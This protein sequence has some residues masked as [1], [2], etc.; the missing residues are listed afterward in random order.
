[1]AIDYSGSAQ[2]HLADFTIDDTSPMWAAISCWFNTDI[3]TADQ[4]LVAIG[5]T[6]EGSR[7]YLRL[8]LISANMLV[9]ETFSLGIQY[10]T[11]TTTGY[12]TGTWH[13]AFGCWQNGIYSV[14]QQQIWIDGGSS[15]FHSGRV[16]TIVSPKLGLGVLPLALSKVLLFNGR[17]AEVAVWIKNNAAD[18][19]SEP[20]V[21]E[22][23]A[24]AKGFSPLTVKPQN[25]TFYAPLVRAVQDVRG[26]RTLTAT[27][28]PTV[29]DHCR[30]IY[31][32]KRIAVPFV[33]A[34]TNRV[35]SL[36]GYYKSASRA[37]LI[38]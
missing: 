16:P 23:V 17:L 2:Y 4:T 9:A 3:S 7:N 30:V 18:D 31:P 15:S 20:T 29:A 22:I 28:S 19:G 5:D 10:A 38:G 21:P 11:G 24:L 27:G 35:V 14:W 12:S 26:G 13:H 37:V 34:A 36:G 33:P 25:L 8:Y 32:H 6:D 1:M